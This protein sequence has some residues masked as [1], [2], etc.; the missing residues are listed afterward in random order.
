[1]EA[2]ISYLRKYTNKLL[3]PESVVS[4][5]GFEPV[6]PAPEAGALSGLSYGDAAELDY[7]EAAADRFAIRDPAY[8]I[9]YRRD[10]AE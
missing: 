9:R 5:T 4:P 2:P 6:H 10:P 3:Y 7:S 8:G 1:M